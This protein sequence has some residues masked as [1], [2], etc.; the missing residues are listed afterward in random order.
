MT[1]NLK[2]KVKLWLHSEQ[3]ETSFGDGKWKLLEAIDKTSSLKAACLELG[4]SY[5][6]AWDNL[7]K[8]EKCLDCNL[9][10]KSRGGQQRGQSQL[11]EKGKTWVR[12]YASFHKD[13]EKAI[14]TAYKK[15]LTNI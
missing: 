15:H 10:S 13:I 7:K 11:T 8:A 3:A 5:R 1:D 4:I 6:K 2:P 14:E 9:V 12:A